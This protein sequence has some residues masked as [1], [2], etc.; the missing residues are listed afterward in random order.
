MK[1]DLT[2]IKGW[3]FDVDDT[4]YLE[5]DYVR[6]GFRAVGDYVEVV[7]GH[8]HFGEICWSH[9]Q[10]GVRSDVFNKALSN[11]KI[12]DPMASASKLVD[13]YRL[14]SPAIACDESIIKVLT[15]LKEH[16]DISIITGGP[17]E[18]Q[19]R[20]VLALGL[21][22]VASN[23]IFS[24][25]LGPALDKPHPWAWREIEN[26]IGLVGNEFIYVGDNPSKDFD[27]PLELG[28]RTLRV[29]Q[30]NSLHEAL[31]TPSGVPECRTLIEGINS[32]TGDLSW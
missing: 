27:A 23:I 20:K 7:T 3:V 19:R 5:R 14:H 9:F 29:R 17:V 15:E 18:S 12:N 8:A 22:L 24:G 21:D 11:L 1:Q 26:R 28:W 13:L 32:I 10:S 31:P 16:C 30:K 4:V 2:K 6:S 25:S